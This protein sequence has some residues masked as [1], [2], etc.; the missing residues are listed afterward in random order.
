M[1]FKWQF[2][3]NLLF[4]LQLLQQSQ[5]FHSFIYNI[6]VCQHLV[7]D[8]MVVLCI[9]N[10]IFINR[11]AFFFGTSFSHFFVQQKDVCTLLRR[12]GKLRINLVLRSLIVDSNTWAVIR[13]HTIVCIFVFIFII[14]NYYFF[15]QYF[16]VHSVL[17]YW[18]VSFSVINF[19]SLTYWLTAFPHIICL[20]GCGPTVRLLCLAL[21][22]FWASNTKRRDFFKFVEVK[23]LQFDI[24]EVWQSITGRIAHEVSLTIKIAN[25]L[26]RVAVSQ[27]LQT[28][29]FARTLLIALRR[30]YYSRWQ[31]LLRAELVRTWAIVPPIRLRLL[32]L[33]VNL[34]LPIHSPWNVSLLSHLLLRWASE[35]LQVIYCITSKFLLIPI[36]WIMLIPYNFYVLHVA[37]LQVHL[38]F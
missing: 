6:V 32:E 10:L 14:N 23:K 28:D 5:S 9:R 26:A 4:F 17:N 12:D 34:L 16:G 38:T 15:V 29:F 35:F 27:T 1:R 8:G 22:I 13:F 30:E 11:F 3:L 21:A 36:I 20:I 2:L 18:I 7:V 33:S 19:L 24:S 31:F 37:G 25:V